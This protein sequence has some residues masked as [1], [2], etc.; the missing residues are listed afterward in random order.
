MPAELRDLTMHVDLPRHVH[1]PG[2]RG[3]ATGENFLY[4]PA[5]NETRPLS[6]SALF[7]K[8]PLSFRICRVYTQ[9]PDH[10]DAIATALDRLV[11]AGG[12]DSITNM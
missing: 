8:I 12:A 9:T 3:G 1:R 7:C 4:D 6:A 5:R 11:A 2:T 10:D